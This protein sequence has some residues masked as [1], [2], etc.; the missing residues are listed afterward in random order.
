[1]PIA[2]HRRRE[3][4]EVALSTSY[5]SR[6]AK[7]YSC[8]RSWNMRLFVFR[9]SKLA[10]VAGFPSRWPGFEPKSG[11]VEFMVDKATLRQVFS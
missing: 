2:P 7:M 11:H 9:Q 1:V 5:C 10:P 4:G 8:M 3:W 6:T